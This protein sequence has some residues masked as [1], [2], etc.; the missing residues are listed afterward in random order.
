LPGKLRPIEKVVSFCPA[1]EETDV[2]ENIV[3]NLNSI[4]E[5]STMFAQ[6]HNNITCERADGQ[7]VKGSNNRGLCV[8]LKLVC[9]N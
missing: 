1:V 4:A 9:K 6:R 2:S 8:N 7:I 5:L 3:A